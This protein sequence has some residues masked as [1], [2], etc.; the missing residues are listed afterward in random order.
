MI[1][2]LVKRKVAVLVAA[3]TLCILGGVATLH[4]PVSLMPDVE[5]LEIT[6]QIN[7]PNQSAREVEESLTS[8]L[9][10]ALMQTAQLTSITSETRDGVGMI[11]LRFAYGTEIDY[12]FLEVN[13]QVDKAMTKLPQK[14]RRPN[15]IKASATDLPVFVLNMSL[16]QPDSTVDGKRLLELSSFAQ[17][18]ISKRLEQ[19]PE[20]ALVDLTGRLFPEIQITPDLEKIQSLGITQKDIQETLDAYTLNLGSLQVK[21]G[22]YVYSVR[23]ASKLQSVEE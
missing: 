9:R 14:T 6:V 18:V 3:F 1:S 12:A 16:Q 13:E 20:I 17:E 22:L 7:G 8:P 11:H 10:R 4:L 2:F 15:V 5:I 19:L 21:S 23:F